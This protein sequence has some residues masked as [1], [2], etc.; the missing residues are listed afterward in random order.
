MGG[1][2]TSVRRHQLPRLPLERVHVE[3]TTHCNF[4]CE[5]CP[6][7]QLERAA[8]SMAPALLEEILAEIAA[9]GVTREVHFHQQGEPLLN[10]NLVAGVERATALGLRSC[11]TSNGAL[12][13]ERRVAALL[14]AGLSKLVVSLQTPDPASFAIRGARG[15]DYAQFEERVVRAVRQVLEARAATEVTVA[16]LTKPLPWLTLPVFGRDW[17][18]VE[19]N[20]DLHELL[21]RWAGRLAGGLDGAPA[22]AAIHRAVRKTGV[23]HRNEVRLHPRLTFEARPVGQWPMPERD[24]GR[25]WVAARW[26]VCHGISEHIAILW[27]GDYTFCCADH[28]GR[29]TTARFQDLSLLDYLDSAPV[30]A[31]LDGFRRL[32]PVHPYCQ[33]CL[34]GPHPMVALVKTIGSIAYFK[35]LHRLKRETR[36]SW[37]AR[38]RESQSGVRPPSIQA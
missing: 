3:V 29:T 14:D 20:R 5:F 37:E 31:A 25:P 30:Q 24:W 10:P 32:R 35:V 22:P 13:D 26:G 33:L 11:I 23:L 16:F 1:R 28:N 12:L 38:D 6:N 34:G 36:A 2:N 15:L 4:A 19:H 7:P 17:Q 21:E 18:I 27:N 8:G 9:S